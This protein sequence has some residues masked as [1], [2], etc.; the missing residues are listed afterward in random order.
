MQTTSSNEI[1][2]GHS[3]KFPFWTK[4]WFNWI[5]LTIFYL[6][7]FGSSEEVKTPLQSIG[8]I[9][10]IFVPIG[11]WSLGT[12][13][14]SYANV[15]LFTTTYI[16]FAIVL[17]IYLLF[18]FDKYLEKNVVIYSKK[19]FLNLLALLVLTMIFD[20]ILFHRLGSWNI[21]FFGNFKGIK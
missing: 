14:D 3:N 1:S 20:L 9:I 19:V 10:G 21:L 16:S 2:V 5:L 6:L 15:T 13:L 4:L 8:A 7:F 18:T 12:I 17:F 11:F